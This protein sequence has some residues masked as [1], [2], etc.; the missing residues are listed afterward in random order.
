MSVTN[1]LLPFCYLLCRWTVWVVCAK[2]GESPQ[3]M[4]SLIKVKATS[5][6]VSLY[7]WSS[8][9]ASSTCWSSW[10]SSCTLGSRLSAQ[11]VGYVSVWSTSSVESEGTWYVYQYWLCVCVSV[12]VY[13]WSVVG[14]DGA[15]TLGFVVDIH[16]YFM[17]FLTDDNFVPEAYSLLF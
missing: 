2:W 9:W 10:W 7:P 3:M 14:S 11:R 12:W 4:I 1:I 16:I 15:R 17:S 5:G 8:T 13:G 6:G